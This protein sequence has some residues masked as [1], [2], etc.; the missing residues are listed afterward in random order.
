MSWMDVF[1]TKDRERSGVKNVMKQK[2]F[3]V[4]GKMVTRNEGEFPTKFNGIS[5][6]P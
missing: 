6:M 3:K 2:P 4:G 5:V 1:M